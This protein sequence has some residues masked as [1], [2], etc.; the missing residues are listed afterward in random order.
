LCAFVF[1]P[2]KRFY[3]HLLDELTMQVRT[4]VLDMDGTRLLQAGIFDSG[5]LRIGDDAAVTSLGDAETVNRGAGS[6]SDILV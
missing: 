1:F 3:L 2:F 4:K 5:V 6:S